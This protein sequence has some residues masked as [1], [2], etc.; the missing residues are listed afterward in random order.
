[1]ANET[2][3][4]PSTSYDYFMDLPGSDL[5][6]YC[7][8]GYNKDFYSGSGTISGACRFNNVSIAQGTTVSEAYIRFHI[9]GVTPDSEATIK[10]KVWGIDEDDTANFSSSPMGRTK[11]S[12]ST[13]VEWGSPT[14][15]SWGNIDVTSIVNEILSRGGW[16]SGNDMGF[17]IFDN[18]TATDTNRF[19]VDDI[20]GDYSFLVVRVTAEPDFTPTPKSVAAPTFP[21]ADDCGIRVSAPNKDVLTVTDSDIWFTTRKRTFGVYEEGEVTISSSPHTITHNLGY[22]PAVLAYANYSG[23]KYRFPD[24]LNLTSGGTIESNLTQAKIY[25][26]AD[27]VYYYIFIDPIELV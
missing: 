21:A 25:T 9:G 13:S 4:S 17:L 7:G 8:F 1:M 23:K 19:I 16:S 20:S 27:K 22:S 3:Y 18:G 24:F 11:T 5:T 10:F 12:E 26:D 6:G 2:T 14:D 15:N